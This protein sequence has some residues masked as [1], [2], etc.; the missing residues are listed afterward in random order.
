MEETTDNRRPT[1]LTFFRLNFDSFVEF[2]KRILEDID[3]LIFDHAVLSS[4]K[5][6][7][8]RGLILLR[9]CN[10]TVS[11]FRLDTRFKTC[12]EKTSDLSGT[13]DL[14]N[15]PSILMLKRI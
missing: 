14:A 3:N 4:I 15:N 5:Y 9:G 7:T 1:E 8:K 2:K 11:I 12:F 6:F 13:F 10:L